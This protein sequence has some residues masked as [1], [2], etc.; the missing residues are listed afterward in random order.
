MLLINKSDICDF[1]GEP[2]IKKNGI[3]HRNGPGYTVKHPD[4]SMDTFPIQG[5][6]YLNKIGV[7]V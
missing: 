2:V 7:I 5:M 1:C 6:Q 3:I 4:C